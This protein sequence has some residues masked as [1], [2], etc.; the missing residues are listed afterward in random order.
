M[1]PTG[2]Q[3]LGESGL[4]SSQNFTGHRP[5]EQRQRKGRPANAGGVS[6]RCLRVTSRSRQ[7]TRLS[8][9]RN[10]LLPS[11]RPTWAC[12]VPQKPRTS[13]RSTARLQSPH[14][15]LPFPCLAVAAFT[16][17]SASAMAEPGSHMTHPEMRENNSLG[18][19]RL[20]GNV[21][22]ASSESGNVF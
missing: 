11:P 18:A 1:P 19:R 5:Q 9:P 14:P 21:V 10:G 17:S 16:C 22:L 13:A 3:T 2:S 12:L 8:A 7:P 4:P 20:L 6:G 15:R